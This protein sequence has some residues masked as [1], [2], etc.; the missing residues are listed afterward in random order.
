MF[1]T[2]YG[3]RGSIVTGSERIAREAFD[4]GIKTG[5][6]TAIM[7]RETTADKWEIIAE[8]T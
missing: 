6:C 5:R 4:A 7:H 1:K 8:H 3:D 2:I